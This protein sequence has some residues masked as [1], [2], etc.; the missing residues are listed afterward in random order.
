MIQSAREICEESFSMNLKNMPLNLKL[1]AAFVSLMFVC[2]IA[3][4]FVYWQTMAAKTAYEQ[5]SRTVEI[6]RTVESA[7]TSMMEE[8][9]NQRGYLLFKTERTLAGVETH[10]D[11]FY[12]K[13]ADAAKLAEG[14]ADLTEAINA[15]DT[16]ARGFARVVSIPQLE[17]RKNTDMAIGEIVAIGADQ[18]RDYQTGLR[19]GVDAIKNRSAE[20]TAAQ[21][22]LQ[23]TA[24]KNIEYALFIGGG[25]AGLIAVLL[26]WLLSRSIVTPIVAMTQTMGRL[27][28]GD[29]TAAV[30]A[31]DRGDEV[32]QMAKAV[33]VFKDAGIEKQRL[34]AEAERLRVIA[35]EERRANELAKEKDAAEAAFASE[36]LAKGLS[37]LANGDLTLRL[38][39]PFAERLDNLRSNFNSAVERLQ[40]TLQKVGVN[41]SAIN[42]GASEMLASADDL[43]RR[44]EQQAASIEETA[45]ALEQVT[46]TVRDSAKGAEE[47]GALVQRARAGAEKSGVVVRNAVAAMKEIEKSSGEIT[48]IIGVIDDIAFQTNLLALNAGV[49]AARAG[50]AGKGFA[51]VA[52]EVRELAQRSANAAKEIKAL[53]SAS[54][55]QVENG[56]NLVDQTGQALQ[57]IVAE[58]EEINTHVSAIVTAAREQSTGL[59]E[60]NMA[61]NTMDQGTQQNA[62]MVEQQTA[63]SHSLAREAEALN[64]MLLQFRLGDKP[65]A[66]QVERKFAPRPM[67]TARPAAPSAVTP[68][69][70]PA[71]PAAPARSLNQ[72]PARS[73]AS[74][75]N[76]AL[77][78][79]EDDWTEF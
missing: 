32:G 35:E 27:A 52:Q 15:V 16:N 74:R 12:Q 55:Q 66:P 29:L 5:H 79:A 26:I 33:S 51:V 20:M 23:A 2:L 30:P 47:A 4:A 68:R 78:V 43:S 8:A 46:T 49:E 25:V 65:R 45:A 19:D 62:A 34:E 9:V 76:A 24:Q 69:P 73:Y 11:A 50:D 1:V 58:V 57:L 28:G 75:G 77:A 13:L 14:Y 3:T 38:N 36:E 10:R 71:R 7:L 53:I 56:V 31:L 37:S 42:A 67:A 17:A 48:N 21:A 54:S 6:A 63:A 59:Q 64:S 22:V 18:A 70:A 41:A 60:I 40:A 44:T 72:A 39:T 61:V